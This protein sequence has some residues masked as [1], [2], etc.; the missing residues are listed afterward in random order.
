MR[1]APWGFITESGAGWKSRRTKTCSCAR[2]LNDVSAC[3]SRDCQRIRPIGSSCVPSRAAA[4]TSGKPLEPPPID[5][6]GNPGNGPANR[7]AELWSNVKAAVQGRFSLSDSD[8]LQA[9]L[10]S[11]RYRYK[12]GCCSNRS[13]TCGGGACPS[14]DEAD[15]VAL[16]FADPDGFP[17][18]GGQSATTAATS[19][20]QKLAPG[21]EAGRVAQRL[22]KRIREG[23]HGRAGTF[24]RTH[25]CKYP[26]A[27]PGA[28][29]CEPLEAAGGVADA[30]P[31]SSAA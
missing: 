23:R 6:K 28:L 19:N 27:E 17:W 21:E 13:R 3:P 31:G 10:V 22:T 20:T 11:C 14:P 18:R 8:S 30:A 15:A 24:T 5:E 26:P 1:P 16:C 7:R 29:G 4:R 25:G 9:D 12:A 2:H